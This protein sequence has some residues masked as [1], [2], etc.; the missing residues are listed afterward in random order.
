M[1]FSIRGVRFGIA[2]VD[3]EDYLI[4]GLRVE[5]FAYLGDE[6]NA[7]GGKVGNENKG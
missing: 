4:D 6:L 1:S 5:R 2:E 3:E 7:E